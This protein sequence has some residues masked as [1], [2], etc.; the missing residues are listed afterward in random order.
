[1]SSNI[2]SRV[3]NIVPPKLRTLDGRA[4]ASLSADGSK[5][6]VHY[7]DN[8]GESRLVLELAPSDGLLELRVASGDLRIC[9][10]KGSVDIEAAHAVRVRAPTAE[11]RVGTWLLR[12]RRIR[13]HAESFLFDASDS[14]QVRAGRIRSVARGVVQILSG[15]TIMRSKEDTAIDGNRILLG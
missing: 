6:S 8:D 12:A 14:M 1:M 3:G 2:L 7:R 13:E 4:E 10:E 5:L 15:R 9:A 11:W